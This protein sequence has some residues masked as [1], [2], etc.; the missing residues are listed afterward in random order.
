MTIVCNLFA[1]P[2][3]GKST[4][5]AEVFAELKW[6]GYNVELVTEQAKKITWDEHW[7]LLQDQY[8]VSALQYRDQQRLRGK[9]EMMIT[10]SP[11]IIGIVYMS[12]QPQE[13]E[14]AML[15]TFDTFDNFNVVLERKKA[16]NP[17]GRSQTEDE[18]RAVDDRI[19]SL[20]QKYEIEVH[21]TTEGT[22]E[23]RNI[24]ADALIEEYGRRY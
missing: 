23:A 5:A 19:N 11:L 22:R 21:L 2:G 6:R 10:D 17:K 9:V 3:C 12:N 14:D 13:V 15:A 18:A 24:I 4:L 16:Y 7:N 8:Y 20:L 1:G